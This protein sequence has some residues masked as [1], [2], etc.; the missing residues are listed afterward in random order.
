[1]VLALA[2]PA[3]YDSVVGEAMLMATAPAIPVPFSV[4]LTARPFA[5]L[6]AFT[7][8]S[9]VTTIEPALT[10]PVLSM[11]A[12]ASLESTFT[13]AAAPIASALLGSFADTTT[14]LVGSRCR[15]GSFA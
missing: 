4:L 10:L 1:M 11:W 15:D 14:I 5:L 9:P 7:A 6:V 13:D 3:M 8:L 12:E 2:V